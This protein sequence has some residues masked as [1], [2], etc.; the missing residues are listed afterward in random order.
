M[1]ETLINT[2]RIAFLLFAIPSSTQETK[3][4]Y[5]EIHQAKTTLYMNKASQFY[6]CLTKAIE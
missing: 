4:K 5:M 2:R 1:K 6:Y 3:D